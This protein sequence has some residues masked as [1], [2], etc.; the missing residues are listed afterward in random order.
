MVW[1][2]LWLSKICLQNN[3][4]LLKSRSQ[5]LR[6]N[7]SPLDMCTLRWW[8]TSSVYDLSWKLH[9]SLG[10]QY[11]SII[12]CCPS[13]LALWMSSSNRKAL[14]FLSSSFT[15]IARCW[16]PLPNDNFFK[17][18]IIWNSLSLFPQTR[19]RL[20][21]EPKK[22]INAH[23]ICMNCVFVCS[24]L[25]FCWIYDK[26]EYILKDINAQYF[27]NKPWTISSFSCSIYSKSLNG[28]FSFS[29][30][31]LPAPFFITA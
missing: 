22:K 12:Y 18:K 9:E 26:V 21:L 11:L 20:V 27:S 2:C 5:H 7:S 24:S 31:N 30:L 17:P 1:E 10:Q 15:M 6:G 8:S 25:H 13:T 28:Y 4:K 3:V 19:I 16:N 14:S 23:W 29:C